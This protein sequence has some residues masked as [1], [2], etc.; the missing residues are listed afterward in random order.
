M[1]IKSRDLGL[2]SEVNTFYQNC[3]DEIKTHIW[4]HNNSLQMLLQKNMKQ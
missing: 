1:W 2:L 3:H 4:I